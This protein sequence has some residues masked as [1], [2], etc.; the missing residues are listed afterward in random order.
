MASV[1]GTVGGLVQ[2]LEC[3]LRYGSSGTFGL[4]IP[5]QYGEITVFVRTVTVVLRGSGLIGV[6]DRDWNA[7]A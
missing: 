2:G 3:T 4:V 1:G 7:H 5:V 6:A